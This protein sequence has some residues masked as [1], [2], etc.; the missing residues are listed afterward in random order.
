MRT[1]FMRLALTVSATAALIVPFPAGAAVTVQFVEPER[2]SDVPQEQAEREHVLR[3]LQQHITALGAR[4]P[5]DRN[6]K[7]EILDIDLAGRAQPSRRSTRDI[8]IVRDRAD[9]PRMHVRYSL[10]AGG[11]VLAR[12]DESLSDMNYRTPRADYRNDKELQYEKKM[13]DDW[14]MRTFLPPR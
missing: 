4:L 3:L 11:N 13:I 12:G 10:E 9:W 8:R 7:L 6:L 14:F 5:A 2:Y 1:S